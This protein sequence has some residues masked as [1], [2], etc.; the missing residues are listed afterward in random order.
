MAGQLDASQSPIHSQ[1]AA[2][3]GLRQRIVCGR[4]GRRH[5]DDVA[6]WRELGVAATGSDFDFPLHP[7]GQRTLRRARRKRNVVDLPGRHKLDQPLRRSQLPCGCRFRE[8]P[9]RG[10][11]RVRI[12]C[13]LQRRADLEQSHRFFGQF[14]PV[15]RIWKRR[16]RGGG[17][18]SATGPCVVQPFELGQSPHA[19]EPF[20]SLPF[21]HLWKQPFRDGRG[22]GTNR[23]V[24]KRSQLGS[25]KLGVPLA[26]YRGELRQRPLH[27]TGAGPGIRSDLDRRDELAC[28]T[29]ELDGFRQVAERCR[30]R[31]WRVRRRRSLGLDSPVW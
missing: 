5:G 22:F 21:R 31:E 14:R 4:R 26:T 30:L 16:V 10:F 12:N 25:P 19:R 23:D 1:F 24:L 28:A 13:G 3:R 11:R 18:V 27:L 2:G 17:G 20:P 6:G 29:D 9:V 15:H 8:W 7:P